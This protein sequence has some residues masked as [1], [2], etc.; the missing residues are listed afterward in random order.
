M[1]GTNDEFSSSK[2][3]L[4]SA[5]AVQGSNTISST[6]SDPSEGRIFTTIHGYYNNDMTRGVCIRYTKKMFVS[7][8]KPV[9]NV[10]ESTG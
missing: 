9:E 4:D 6:T 7:V 3:N 8:T 2:S 1:D 5:T 10:S